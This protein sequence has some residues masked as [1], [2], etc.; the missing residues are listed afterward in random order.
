[1][2]TAKRGPGRP[3]LSPAAVGTDAREQILEV[4]AR[5]FLAHGYA[6]T[7]TREIAAAAGLRPASLFYWFGR[8][9]DILVELLDRT[10][11]PALAVSDAMRRGALGPEV[12][13]FALARGDVRNLCSGTY[14]LAALQLLAEARAEPFAPFWARRAELRGRYRDLLVAI[15]RADRLVPPSVELATDIVFG[16]VE[17]VITWFDR[18]GE[19]A[20]S[21]AADAVALTVVRGVVA[22]PMSAGR[23]RSGADRFGLH[24]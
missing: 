16:A 24:H 8:K 14:N 13:L 22:R 21:A 10:V 5:L 23:L 18:G 1:M 15:E 12:G 9:E 6:A 4:A 20:A 7:G 2:T 3:R 19:F 17:S 11:E